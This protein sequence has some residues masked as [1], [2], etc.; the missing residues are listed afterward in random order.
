MVQTLDG[1]TR[2]R[3]GLNCTLNVRMVDWNAE[4]YHELSAPQQA[5]GRRVLERL[6]LAGT[7]TRARPRVRH[8]PDHVGDRGRVPR[9]D[10][11]GLDRSDVDAA[12]PRRPGCGNTHPAPVSCRPTARAAVRRV[13]DAVFSGA[14]FHWILDHAALFRSIITALVRADDWSRSAAAR[15]ISRNCSA[16]HRRLMARAAFVALLRRMDRTD[17]LRGR[18]VHQAPAGRGRLRRR[19]RVA[20]GGADDVRQ[21]RRLSSEFIATVC[22]RHHLSRLPMR[23]A[24]RVPPRADARRGAR[25]SRRSRSTTG[26]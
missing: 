4:R 3:S 22:V 23:R 5:W 8:G 14:T 11:V 21:R 1:A 13:F 26:A 20:R 2:L 7:R 19:R 10:V 16:A 17:L 12:R 9:G 15:A 25:H 18:R 6:P 24:A